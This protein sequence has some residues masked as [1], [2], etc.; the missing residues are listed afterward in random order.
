MNT[1]PEIAMLAEALAKAQGEM[2]H[3]SKD[4]TNPAFR[5]RYATLASVI[6]ATRASLSK[7]GL[8]I[9]QAVGGDEGKVEVLTRLCHASGQWIEG[10]MSC[11]PSK[12]D[13]QGLGS[14]VTYLRRY[15]LS[16]LV[17][18]APDDPDDDGNAASG[19]A[20]EPQ[21]RAEPAKAASARQAP[22]P[23]ADPSPE[24]LGSI[25]TTNGGWSVRTPASK[26]E[27]YRHQSDLRIA[28]GLPSLTSAS[29]LADIDLACKTLAKR[30]T[31][32]QYKELG[33]EIN[34]LKMSKDRVDSL[35]TSHDV[36]SLGELTE[37]QALLLLTQLSVSV[38]PGEQPEL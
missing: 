30:V 9:V 21:K 15:G 28:T 38:T 10:V 23:A 26:I 8:S 31:V 16:S 29:A 34:R 7:H 22:V 24:V 32:E 36:K 4:A 14:C 11:R 17:G 19:R 25:V 18:I 6:E 12:Q 35:R 27:W 2:T 5:S 20:H 3:A 13:A 33:V 1:S 37:A